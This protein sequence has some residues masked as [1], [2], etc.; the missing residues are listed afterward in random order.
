MKHDQK[1]IYLGELVKTEPIEPF[2]VF[3]KDR[4][5]N[6]LIT[7]NAGTGKSILIESLA[8]QDFNNH[9]G[10]CVIDP[11]GSLTKRLLE[12]M[13]EHRVK[14]LVYLDMSEFADVSIE[15]FSESLTHRVDFQNAMN[16]KKIILINLAIGATGEL[17]AREL[18]IA[19]IKQISAAADARALLHVDKEA[20][21]QIFHLYIDEIARFDDG[22]V[23]GLL[24]YR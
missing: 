24:G 10:V 18:G 16:H 20:D 22:A 3:E 1:I 11:Y 9:E 19:I 8:I 6:I 15:S 7:G 21:L 23:Q 13:P 2:G 14:D 12:N 17:R 5:K 4:L